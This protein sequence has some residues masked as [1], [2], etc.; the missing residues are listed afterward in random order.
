MG[1]SI[2]EKTL[3]TEDELVIKKLEKWA[4]EIPNKTYLYYGEDDKSLTFE[5]FNEITNSI[6]NNLVLSGIK[7]GD[8]IAVF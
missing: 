8:R 5:Y 6:A 3:H 4:K 1:I 7:K 2:F